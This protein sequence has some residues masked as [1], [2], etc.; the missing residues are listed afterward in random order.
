MSNSLLINPSAFEAGLE[1]AF[2]ARTSVT[3][4]HGAAYERFASQ[5]LPNRRRE[6][7]KWSDYNAA[8]RSVSPASAPDAV[9]TIAPSAF[10]PL[11]PIEIQIVNGRVIL[12]TDAAPKGVRFGIMDAVGTIPELETHAI[13]SMNVAMSPKAFG[14]EIKNG[15][16]FNRPVLIRH[17]GNGA[18]PIFSQTMIR[19]GEKAFAT[20]IETYEGATP[21]LASHLCHLVIR[22]GGSLNRFIMNETD[23]N[24]VNHS[25]C[26]AK[27]EERA[28]FRQT[29]LS[30]G[31]R[32]SR[33]E[34]VLHFWGEGAKAQIDSA[35]LLRSD[36]HADF[37]THVLHKAPGCETRQLHKGVADEKGRAVFQGKFEVQRAAQKTDAKMTANALLLSNG[38]EANHKPEL[39]IYA[40][41]VECAHGSTC[42]ALDADA[43]F[44]LRQRGLNEHQARALL[45]E[46]FAG[47]VIDVIENDEIRE[48]YTAKV[49]QW[50]EAR[51]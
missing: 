3:E 40:D 14:L 33:H 7:W 4:T 51:A 6:G 17:I 20:I 44:Y 50:L 38:A 28:H 18:A 48:V 36:R 12:P 19:V 25:I 5:H 21:A 34:T 29:S 23:D 15:V 32:L 11:D 41:D 22:D 24:T 47:E 30:T 31:A 10:A 13:A 39:E 42:G 27:I 37:T 1:A 2:R 49:S 9:E 45:I 46:A 8:L 43:L 16:L 26:A 35:A